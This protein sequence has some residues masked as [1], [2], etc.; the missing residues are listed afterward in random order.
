VVFLAEVTFCC[1]GLDFGPGSN[2]IQNV[3]NQRCTPPGVS[4]PGFSFAR[5]LALGPILLAGVCV[6]AQ[7]SILVASE[8][9]GPAASMSSSIHGV[10]TSTDGAVYEGAR[11]EVELSGPGAPPAVSQQ[12]DSGGAFN[13]VN[14]PAGTFKITVSS[15]GFVTQEIRG[16]LHAGEAYDARTIVLPMAAAA[17]NIVVSAGS[18]AEI[19]QQQ[20]NLEEQQRVLGVFPNYYVTY[21]HDAVPLTARQKYQLAWRTEIDPVTLALTGV[22]AGFEQADNTFASYG[23]GLEGY[24][25][26]YGANYADGFFGN[27]IGGAVLPSVLKQDPRYFYKGTGTVRSRA[28]YAIANAVICKGDNGRWQPN[29][30]AV[31]GGIAAGGIS[32]LYYPDNQHSGVE[33]TFESALI[34]TAQTAMQNL[35][36]EFLV[37]RLTP[38]LPLY[39]SAGTH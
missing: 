20:L 5:L 23:Q 17:S 34:G 36:Q 13:F 38:K 31:L 35:F 14:L 37:R 27:M 6:W 21:D 16:E 22:V 15:T 30:S 39:P 18:R 19:A 4:P 26:R 33:L 1:N 11:V 2:Q 12:T 9:P 24:A 29:Y 3:V 28:L 25:K 32:N 10:V 7:Q 8:D